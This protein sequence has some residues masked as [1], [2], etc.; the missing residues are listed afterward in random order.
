[1]LIVED[2]PE[3]R[4]LLRKILESLDFEVHEAG[5]GQ[6]ALTLFDRWQP[7]LIWMDIR[8]PV[9]DGLEATRRIKSTEAGKQT[10]IIALTAHALEEERVRILSAGC[11]DFIRKP[12]QGSEIFETLAKHLDVRFVYSGEAA[13][14]QEAVVPAAAA[15]GALPAAL[16]VELE[17][18]LVGLDAEAVDAVIDR[19][20]R[21]HAEL[22][23]ALKNL[24][25]A[26][27]YGKI[28]RLLEDSRS[29]EKSEERE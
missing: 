9:M 20:R 11:D 21:H 17:Q 16:A 24:A 19:I 7:H 25:K 29:K 3:N 6:E 23:V 18:A 13:S 8:M 12:Y 22:A 26:F 10:K 5:N 14:E 15:L 28:L 4:L 2:Q 1:L 27:Q